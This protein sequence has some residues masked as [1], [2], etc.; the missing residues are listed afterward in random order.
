MPIT[1]K[2][3]LIKPHKEL[4]LIFFNS[5]KNSHWRPSKR[6]YTAN[7]SVNQHSLPTHDSCLENRSY[8]YTH[9]ELKFLFLF[10]LCKLQALTHKILL[11]KK[12]SHSCK[13]CILIAWL[14]L[15]FYK[16]NF[17]YRHFNKE[18][19]EKPNFQCVKRK[20]NS[21]YHRIHRVGPNQLNWLVVISNHFDRSDTH[22]INI[23]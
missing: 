9:T 1:N 23:F 13:I 5:F 12:L 18:A 4:S 17:T 3:L 11:I 8:V 22:L 10:Y 20:V 14:F 7:S 6:Y 15:L 19:S 2:G 16:N 21:S